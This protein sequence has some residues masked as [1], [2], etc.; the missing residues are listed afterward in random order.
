MK[1]SKKLLSSQ[2]VEKPLTSSSNGPSPT[3]DPDPT[4]KE[5]PEKEDSLMDPD[6]S[7]ECYLPDEEEVSKDLLY[8]FLAVNAITRRQAIRTKALTS[9]EAIETVT[10]PYAEQLSHSSSEV[11]HESNIFKKL[12]QM[13]HSVQG[14]TTL[15]TLKA[16]K[17]ELT[18]SLEA[19]LAQFKGLDVHKVKKLHLQIMK[20]NMIA[21][22]SNL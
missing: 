3:L 15:E 12:A 21:F 11:T 16:L 10:I 22:I 13:L 2:V 20:A 18:S 1:R 7:P 6:A 8:G 14:L 17:P 9:R 19:F 5:P 4:A